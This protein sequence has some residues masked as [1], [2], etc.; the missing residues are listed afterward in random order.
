MPEA[1][2]DTRRELSIIIVKNPVLD[3]RHIGFV[4]H[5][6]NQQHDLRFNTFWVDQTETPEV[7]AGQLD[8]FA[9]F[10]WTL[11]HAPDPIV[12]GVTC[13][14]L[15]HRFAWLMEHAEMGRWF[16]YL[17]MECIPEIDFTA[18]ILAALPDLE[19]AFG[20]RQICALQQLRCPL[21]RED[22]DQQAY[23]VQLR[24]SKVTTWAGRER[25]DPTK[26]SLIFYET[27]WREDAFMMP[28]A[29]ARELRLYSAPQPPLYFQDVFD[30]LPI[31]AMR[32]YGQ[33]ISWTRLPSALI[34]HLQHPRAYLEFR[35]EFFAAVRQQPERFGHLGLYDVAARDLGY[36]ET[37][38]L[39][40]AMHT[41]HLLSIFYGE[42]R[43][44]PRGTLSHW[45][46]A[47]DQ[48]HGCETETPTLELFERRNTGV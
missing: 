28:S 40:E 44:G 34:Y 19:R 43:L 24:Q 38:A 15:V 30:I 36:I 42:F 41:P 21:R 45:H 37:E 26:R 29:L 46:R 13:W 35:R 12:A 25:I 27:P 7:L 2:P 32:P 8:R 6:L 31:L 17:H 47:L 22:L 18:R 9:R 33:D 4:I 14:E 10:D 39:R 23:L 5:A 1:T 3:Q 11:V 16:T 48:A 20:K